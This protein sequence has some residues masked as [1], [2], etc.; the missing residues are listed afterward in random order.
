MGGN[1]K[2]A[3]TSEPKVER[4]CSECGYTFEDTV[5]YSADK[6]CPTCK[7]NLQTSENLVSEIAT[8]ANPDT[9]DV[10]ISISL[11]ST[12]DSTLSIPVET[13]ADNRDELIGFLRV[14]ADTD[15]WY[16]D[17]WV[18]EDET[19]GYKVRRGADGITFTWPIETEATGLRSEYQNSVGNPF[20]AD[21][22]EITFHF[23]DPNIDDLSTTIELPTFLIDL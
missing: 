16:E 23:I 4:T 17:A 2:D 18:A 13:D 12:V 10:K 3:F 1:V 14:E 11:N 5:K 7:D 6:F 20:D 8:E 22:L 19:Y 21:T 9:G 15:D